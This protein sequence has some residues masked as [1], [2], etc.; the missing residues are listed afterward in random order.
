MKYFPDSPIN[1]TSALSSCDGETPDWRQAI[2][3]GPNM[4]HF[5]CAYMRQQEYL[6][7][8]WFTLI[9]AWISNNMPSEM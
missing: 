7:S 5:I 3:P 4:L 1:D 8:H 6:Y 9:R 2:I